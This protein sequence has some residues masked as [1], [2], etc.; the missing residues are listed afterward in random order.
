[1]EP[2]IMY[3]LALALLTIL[4]VAGALFYI[5]RDYRYERNEYR[6][7]DKRRKERLRREARKNEGAS[8]PIH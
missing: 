3:A 4:C 5:S 2:R 1:M 8:K 6:R 7:S